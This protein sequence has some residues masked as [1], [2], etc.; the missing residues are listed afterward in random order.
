VF[1]RDDIAGGLMCYG[2]P[3]FK[4]EKHRVVR[5]IEQMTAEGVVFKTNTPVGAE[6]VAL[7]ALEDEFDAVCL[8]I[9]AQRHRRPS[10]PG[11]ELKGVCEGMDYL[12]TENRR[13]RGRRYRRRLRGH[14]PPPGRAT[15]GSDQHPPATA[16]ATS[17]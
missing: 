12:R 4:F 15:G 5:R 16:G 14:R 9:G 7:K 13:Q 17:G 6:G 3:D 8:T 10:L 11:I 2:I 1:E